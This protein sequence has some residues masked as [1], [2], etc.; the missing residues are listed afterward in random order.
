MIRAAAG[1]PDIEPGLKGDVSEGSRNAV[2]TVKHNYEWYEKKSHPVC[3]HRHSG[4]RSFCFA[5]CRSF[6][7]QGQ[8]IHTTRNLWAPL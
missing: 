8:A 4:V 1:E 7:C 6:S 5:P 3:H 2:D